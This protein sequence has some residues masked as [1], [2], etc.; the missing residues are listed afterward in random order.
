MGNSLTA[1][2]QCERQ[3]Q[4]RCD[5]TCKGDKVC[6][7]DDHPGELHDDDGTNGEGDVK[8]SQAMINHLLLKASRD[9]DCVG[10]R[11]SL[12]RGAY[13]ET[14]RP[15]IMTPESN[16]HGSNAASQ[17]RGVGLTPLMY[18]AQGGYKQACELLLGANACMQAEDE[19][20][21]MPI[22]FAASSGSTDTVI[23]LLQNGAQ[24]DSADDEGRTPMDHVPENCLTTQAHRRQ[25][26]AA[27]ETQVCQE[28][29]LEE[30]PDDVGENK[31]ARG[32]RFGNVVVR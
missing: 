1:Q 13:V 15:F 11:R 22:H 3:F 6:W 24:A 18:A 9:G 30:C 25:W 14:R 32:G 27:M 10:I 28:A 16:S 31:A 8:N 4:P 12:G 21:L 17:T 23:L 7:L 26:K 2:C 19:D 29:L 20:G 5:P